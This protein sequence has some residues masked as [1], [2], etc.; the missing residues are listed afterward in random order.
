MS[1]AVKTA[2]GAEAL[3]TLL[4]RATKA[5]AAAAC[6]QCCRSITS[7]AGQSVVVQD[8]HHVA[9]VLSQPVQNAAVR[10]SPLDALRG[11]LGRRGGGT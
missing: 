4:R 10:L 11:W 8:L 9:A 5:K 1:R 3:C 6:D 7:A 2:V